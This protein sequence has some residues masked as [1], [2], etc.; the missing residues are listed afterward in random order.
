MNATSPRDDGA[1]LRLDDAKQR[2]D[3]AIVAIVD[4]ES[5]PLGTALGRVLAHHL[6][7]QIDVPAHDNAAMDGYALH[8]GNGSGT[9]SSR[10]RVLG[11]AFAGQPY[12]G[13]VAPGECV[14][15]MTGAMMPLDCDAVVPQEDA[16]SH[17]D[18]VEFPR[19]VQAGQHLR[20]AGE[21]LERGA[22]AIARGRRITPSDLGL[23]ASIGASTMHVVRRPR[24]AIFSTGT[25]LRALDQVLD[26]GSVHDSN[27][28]TLTGML[29]RLGAEVI[30]LGIVRD[31]RDALEAALKHACGEATRADA[32]VTS[33]GVSAGEADYTREVME[34]I[35]RVAFWK[36]AIKPGRPMAFGRIEA[37]D[38]RAG[39][40][41]LL[42]G[43]PG[44]PV[45]MMV[46]FHALVRDALVKLMGARVEPLACLQLICDTPLKK[47]VGRTEF[48]R[49]IA[50][51]ADDG[52]RVRPT[53]AQGSG[54]LHSMSQANCLI[55]LDHDRGNVAS[56]EIVEAWP[57]DGLV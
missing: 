42:F 36:L 34:K 12:T 31:D 9:G 3:D 22:V 10:R 20:R 6:I 51:R 13:S 48:V 35:G 5:I 25:E 38:K 16:I 47:T 30:D 45:A 18:E 46:V 21:D 55:V 4:V 28:Y 54:M 52:W 23:A 29:A 43:L 11:R 24:V 17:G 39:R 33:G 57:F 2:I 41:A 19:G 56:G 37:I 8:A 15:I 44:N 27:R 7:S 53:G 14:R 50:V 40:P 32:I 49:G 1:A 26:P